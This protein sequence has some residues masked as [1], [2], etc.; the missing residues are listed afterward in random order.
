MGLIHPEGC[1]DSVRLAEGNESTGEDSMDAE[2]KTFTKSH[3]LFLAL[4]STRKKTSARY[5]SC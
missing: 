4:M 3:P 5:E 2:K 1:F